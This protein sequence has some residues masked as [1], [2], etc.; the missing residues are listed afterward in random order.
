MEF[1]RINKLSE[2]FNLKNYQNSK[3]RNFWEL[4]GEGQH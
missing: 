4:L 1:L 3:N 2:F